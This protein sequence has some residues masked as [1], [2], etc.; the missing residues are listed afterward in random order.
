MKGTA[1]GVLAGV[2]AAAI[3]IT[4]AVVVADAIELTDVANVAEV[5]D[6]ALTAAV[7]T[8]AVGTATLTG[9]EALAGRG[10][11]TGTATGPV[12][13]LDVTGAAEA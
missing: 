4:D 5:T 9:T 2:R 3:F 6:D 10:D 8:G 11:E 12:A 13:T 1:G 7:A